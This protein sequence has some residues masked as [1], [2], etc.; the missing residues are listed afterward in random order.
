MNGLKSRPE[1]PPGIA[2]FLLDDLN[3]AGAINAMQALARAAEAGDPDAG[4]E[5]LAAAAFLGIEL[6]D[7][8]VE[9]H[10]PPVQEALIRDAIAECLALIRDK[11]WAAA[12]RIR[13]ELLGQ[14]IQLKD[15][16]DPVTGERV[17][18]W[19]VRR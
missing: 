11:N 6:R 17:T 7:A 3:T 8:V 19:E 16:K 10:V 14:G 18:T 1:P 4:G 9:P 15:A 12:D 2:R 5:V 13:D